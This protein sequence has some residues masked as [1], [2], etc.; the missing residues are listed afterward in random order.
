MMPNKKLFDVV[1]D[2]KFLLVLVKCLELVFPLPVVRIAN[3]GLQESDERRNREGE[4]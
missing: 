1:S 3:N 4:V 2:S